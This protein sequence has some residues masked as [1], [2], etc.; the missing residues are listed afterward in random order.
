M[1]DTKTYQEM[2]SKRL[3]SIEKNF[4]NETKRHIIIIRNYYL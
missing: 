1:K 2:K 4:I 3:H